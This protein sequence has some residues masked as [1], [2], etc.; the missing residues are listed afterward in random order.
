MFATDFSEIND[1]HEGCKVSLKTSPHP[2]P[3]QKKYNK[4]TGASLLERFSL[5]IQILSWWYLK[6]ICRYL[7]IETHTKSE[8]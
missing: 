8:S 6:I 7:S 1:M 2:P 3:P 4:K 5:A